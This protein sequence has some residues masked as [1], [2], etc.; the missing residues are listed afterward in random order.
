MSSK[1]SKKLKKKEDELF[2]GAFWSGKTAAKL[3]LVDEVADV[4]SKMKEK[5]G[6][7][8]KIVEIEEKKGFIKGLLSEKLNISNKLGASI[9]SSLEERISFSKFGL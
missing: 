8:V 1:R 9:I 5:F 3:G 4:R 7:K 2:T 6:K